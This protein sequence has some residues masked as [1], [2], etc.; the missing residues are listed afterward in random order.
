MATQ[1]LFTTRNLSFY[2]KILNDKV[3]YGH[4]MSHDM[5]EFFESS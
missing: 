2:D 1:P 4:I 3:S 5:M